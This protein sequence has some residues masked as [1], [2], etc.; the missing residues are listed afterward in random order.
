MAKKVVTAYGGIS[1][2]AETDDEICERFGFKHGDVVIT[3]FGEEA[4]IEGVAPAVKGSPIVGQDVMWYTKN[5][6][7][8]YYHGPGNLRDRGFAL[9]I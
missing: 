6:G 2:P 3:P 4:M 5:D 9:K 7:V 1:F 8:A